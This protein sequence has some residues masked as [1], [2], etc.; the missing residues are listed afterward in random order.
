MAYK[1]CPGK[2]FRCTSLTETNG[3]MS[4]DVLLALDSV[5]RFRPLAK[6]Y[7]ILATRVRRLAPLTLARVVKMLRSKQRPRDMLQ[8]GYMIVPQVLFPCFLSLCFCSSL[9]PQ[10]LSISLTSSTYC[11][12]CAFVCL[13]STKRMRI[14][15][16]FVP[17]CACR[18]A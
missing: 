11:A 9:Q 10:R 15:H 5:N 18:G 3:M 4:L 16:L 14:K 7:L 8:L 13:L 6:D 12:L 1:V 2:N 17:L